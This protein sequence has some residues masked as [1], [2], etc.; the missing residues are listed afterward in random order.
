MSAAE[1]LD[2]PPM[3]FDEFVEFE[4]TSEVRHEIRGGV[5]VAM[6]G[7]TVQHDDVGG[8]LRA[9]FR[10]SYE[11]GGYKP[12]SGHLMVYQPAFDC[13]VYPDVTVTC[14]PQEFREEADPDEQRVLLN[15]TLIVEVLSPSTYKR[16]MGAKFE[17]YESIPSLR[18]YVLIDP[19]TPWVRRIVRNE[20][21]WQIVT[22]TD[23]AAAVPL[24][25]VGVELPMGRIYFGV[26][27][28]AESAIRGVGE[29][30]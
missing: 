8:N 16:D 19:T 20:A 21:G 2:R 22:T 14:G 30:E 1:Q 27:T 28:A 26:E 25:S 9:A 17:R 13:G 11:A 6:A 5:L 4:R 12:N 10:D 15:P 24:E 7:G 18:E 23:A 29:D 3:T